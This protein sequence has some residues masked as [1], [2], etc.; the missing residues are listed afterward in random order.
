ML[1]SVLLPNVTSTDAV[2]AEKEFDTI[3]H[4]FTVAP[5]PP[6]A[7]SPLAS[8]IHVMA[9]ALKELPL[10]TP[11]DV[12]KT[13]KPAPEVFVSLPVKVFPAITISWVILFPC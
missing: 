9:P 5:N 4:P 2:D 12:S 1:S 7:G 3:A 6:S 8:I 13:A 11:F 10:M